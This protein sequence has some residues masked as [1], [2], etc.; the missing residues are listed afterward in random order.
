MLAAC[1]SAGHA[2]AQM[3]Q[4]KF[5]LPAETRWGQATL[6]A[7]E[8][9]FTLDSVTPSCPLRIR[10]GNT[11]VGMFFATVQGQNYSGHAEL[12]VEKG[13]VRAL[14][15]PKLGMVYEYAPQHRTPPTATEEREIAQ[16]VPVSV[17]VQ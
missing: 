3:L 6:P 13:T 10:R 16:L 2:N 17:T 8:Y 7:G 1:F 15:L 11:N 12:R 9:S 5:T 14:N 4:G